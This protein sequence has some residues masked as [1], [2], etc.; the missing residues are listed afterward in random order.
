MRA[1]SSGNNALVPGLATLAGLEYFSLMQLLFIKH[2]LIFSPDSHRV[3]T[4][5]LIL[6]SSQDMKLLSPSTRR[7]VTINTRLSDLVSDQ[8]LRVLTVLR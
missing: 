2:S 6:I 3:L 5:N 4:L 1:E 8:V 7:L